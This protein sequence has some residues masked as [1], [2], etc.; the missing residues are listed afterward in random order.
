MR[1]QTTWREGS[2]LRN[3]KE[4][5]NRDAYD[6]YRKNRKKVAKGI[7]Q[8]NYFVKAIN[9]IFETAKK[10][11]IES[12]GGIYIEGFGYFCNILMPY[13][14]KRKRKVQN[15]LIKRVR[16]SDKYEPFFE[17]D[18]E[19]SGWCMDYAFLRKQK[20]DVIASKV[21]YKIHFDLMLPMRVMADYEKT[22][23]RR[24]YVKTFR[25]RDPVINKINKLK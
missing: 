16:I 14:I 2:T 6:Y 23:K 24:K 4:I 11:L 10:M 8:Y 19:F 12:K 22:S 3:P 1:I 17:P 25:Y 18:V 20:E 13:K 21:K 5:V 15:S 7:D 9:G